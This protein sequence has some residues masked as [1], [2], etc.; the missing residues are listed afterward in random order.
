MSR[1]RAIGVNAHGASLAGDARKGVCVLADEGE[2]AHGHVFS[3]DALALRAQAGIEDALAHH[4]QGDAQQRGQ[5]QD[6]VVI[7][8][9]VSFRQHGVDRAVLHQRDAVGIVDQAARRQGV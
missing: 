1:K 8:D 4:F 9:H 5:A 6:H 7:L 3:D 2:A